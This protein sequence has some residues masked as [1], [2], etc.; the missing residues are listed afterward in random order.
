MLLFDVNVYVYAP[1][2]DSPHHSVCK[3]YLKK[4][5]QENHLS[6]YSPLALSGFIRIVTHPKIFNPASTVD[7]ALAFCSSVTELPN[8]VKILPGETHWR[9]FTHFLRIHKSRGNLVPDVWFAALAVEHGCTWVTTD[10]DYSR[11]EGLK[12]EYPV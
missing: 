11:F 6:G 2:E 1:R 12:I 7:D 5:L 4:T 10:R 9:I 8:A 3:K